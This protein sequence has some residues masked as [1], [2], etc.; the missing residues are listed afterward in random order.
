MARDEKIEQNEVQPTQEKKK[1][2]ALKWIAIIGVVLMV[3]AAAGGGGWYYMNKAQAAKKEA[4]QAPA[5]GAMWPM[6]PF[7]V[8]L[9]DSNGERYLKLVIQLEVSDPLCVQE[10]DQLKP[11]LRDNVLDLLSVKTYKELMELTGKQKLREE[12]V[13][14]LNA[15]LT[16]GKI[17]KV[18]FTEFVI[19]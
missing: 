9:A 14:R 15:F 8:N 11:K 13:M 17:N 6:E 3:L 4:P 5:I 1:G 18:Y 19:Q 7:I 12:M 2:S 10:L 16:K